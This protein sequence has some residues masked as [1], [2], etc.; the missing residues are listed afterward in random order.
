MDKVADPVRDESLLEQV[1][2]RFK[3]WF[4]IKS[5]H[6]AECAELGFKLTDSLIEQE[7]RAAQ[8]SR[9]YKKQLSEREKM[10]FKYHACS[11]PHWFLCLPTYWAISST[12]VKIASTAI[13][14]SQ[15]C[16]TVADTIKLKKIASIQLDKKNYL[17]AAAKNQPAPAL[18]LTTSV[19]AS[20]ILPV[21]FSSWSWGK[22]TFGVH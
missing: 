14:Y 17:E 11:G 10:T 6:T 7:P 3:I 2:F 4:S 1:P 22:S 8:L 16:I 15:L 5:F 20:W 19:P 21:S 9:L 13:S 18:A 12:T